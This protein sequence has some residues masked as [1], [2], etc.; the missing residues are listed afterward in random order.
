MPI[1]QT[2]NLEKIFKGAEEFKVLNDINIS[3]E[4]GEFVS[5]IGQ[6]GSGKSTLLYVLSTLDTNY[7]GQILVN[8]TNLKS[9]NKN[10]LASFRNKEI[11]FVFQFHYLLPEFTVAEN[12]S[13]PALK[14]GKYS[15]EEIRERALQKLDMLGLKVHADKKASQLSGGQQQRVAIARALINDPK[16]LFGDEPTGNL[17]SQNSKMVFEIFQELKTNFKQTIVIVTHDNDIAAKTDRRITLK[18]GIVVS[19]N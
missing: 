10:Q 4:T 1:I 19:T 6:S 11:G 8:G 15:Q 14:L 2:I 7:G 12:V 18:D 5:I 16:I 9:L 3:I 13:L 17:D